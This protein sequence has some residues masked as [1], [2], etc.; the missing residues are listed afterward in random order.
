MPFP[1]RAAA[2][3]WFGGGRV[4]QAWADGLEAR[5]DGLWPRFDVDVLVRSLAAVH[6]AEA[7]TEWESLSQPTLLVF[8]S[9]G[10]IPGTEIDRMLQTHPRARR[11]T[12]QGAGHDLHLEAADKW[13]GILKEFL[14]EAGH[15]TE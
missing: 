1:D 5:G 12:L 6:K 13:L 14:A 9:H 2:S 3:K 4:G 8:G 10:L 7:W 11:E 15:S